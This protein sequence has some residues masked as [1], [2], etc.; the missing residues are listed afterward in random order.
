[1]AD[2]SGSAPFLMT[3]KYQEDI[4]YLRRRHL[5]LACLASV[6]LDMS[7]AEVLLGKLSS[8]LSGKFSAKDA[9]PN[10]LSVCMEGGLG[11]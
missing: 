8:A 3:S 9:Q 7:E 2:I 1:M 6:A 10:V 11:L 4:V 5:A